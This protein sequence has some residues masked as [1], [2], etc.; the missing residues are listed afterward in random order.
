MPKKYTLVT[1]GAGYIGSHMAGMLIEAGHDVVIF[2]NLSTGVRPWLAKGAIF[3][4]GDLLT[5]GTVEKVFKK[6][7]IHA[8]IHF[9]AKIVVPESVRHPGL[10]YANN[11]G[12]T[13]NLLTAM[14]AYKVRRIVFSSTASV[15]GNPIKVPVTEDSPTLPCNP[16]GMSKLIVEQILR[17]MAQAQTID[18]IALRYFNVAGWDTRRAWPIKGRPVPT[19]LISN[20]MKAL[21][22]AGPLIVCGK[23]YKTKDGTGVRDFIHV[24]DLCKAHLLALK[25]MEKGIKNQVFNLGSGD[26]FSVL[27]V[28]K[29]SSK[30]A[31]KPVPHI[32]GPR[33]SGDVTTLVASAKKAKKILGWKPQYDLNGILKSEWERRL[34]CE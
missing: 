1:G 12:G 7:P 5:S 16:Y 6:Y 11:V 2:D 13:I 20:A 9:A 24:L 30:V 33:R 14:A 26:G 15:Y 28:I 25:A 19:H 21:Y 3:V 4:Q 32:I 8:V 31:G 17:D 27:D 29:A 18:Y 10:Y 22:G 23:D 34:S